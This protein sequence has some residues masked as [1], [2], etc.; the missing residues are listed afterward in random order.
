MALQ[1]PRVHASEGKETIMIQQVSPQSPQAVDSLDVCQV[2]LWGICP[3]LRAFVPFKGIEKF[4]SYNKAP[5]VRFRGRDG[6]LGHKGQMGVS[7]CLAQTQGQ[8][9]VPGP[10]KGKGIL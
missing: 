2:V 8:S 5:A 9:S 3:Y 4:R 7:M 10:G 1:Q 6:T